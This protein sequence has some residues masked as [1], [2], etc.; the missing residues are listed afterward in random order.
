MEPVGLIFMFSEILG[1]RSIKVIS[2]RDDIYWMHSSILSQCRDLSTGVICTV[3]RV[4]DTIC[5]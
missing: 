4:P 1:L 3:F 2:E 5:E